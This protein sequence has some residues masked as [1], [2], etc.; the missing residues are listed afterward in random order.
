MHLSTSD[1][2]KTGALDIKIT[3]AKSLPQVAQD[4]ANTRGT[5]ITLSPYYS[6]ALGGSTT[7]VG[8]NPAGQIVAHG[9]RQ[10]DD[11]LTY[12]S[13]YWAPTGCIPASA[14]PSG[15]PNTWATAMSDAGA[16]VGWGQSES[17]INPMTEQ[18][19]FWASGTAPATVLA[20]LAGAT[21]VFPVGVSNSGAIVAEASLGGVSRVISWTS[22]AASPTVLQ[23]PS[24]YTSSAAGGVNSSGEI[25]GW[26]TNGTNSVPVVWTSP[27]REPDHPPASGFGRRGRRGP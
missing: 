25:V 14:A 2:T 16:I 27:G 4:D 13:M 23:L 15:L 7:F 9:R 8:M 24:G 6:G 18:P 20:M 22:P 19:L 1:G 3:V 11:P 10:S 5:V 26:L 12:A 21:N 17:F